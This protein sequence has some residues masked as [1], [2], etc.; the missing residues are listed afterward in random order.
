MFKVLSEPLPG[1]YILSNPCF[2]D[3]RGIF[4]KTFNYTL[5]KDLDIEFTPREQFSTISS[6]NVL[7]GMHFQVQESS[8]NKL[9]SCNSGSILDVIVDVRTSSPYY[10]MPFSIE[11]SGKSNQLV[12]IGKGYAHG[13]LSL[14]ED[15]L[16]SYT[17]DKEY[18]Q[19]LDSGVHWS[20][21]NY[22]WPVERPLV[23]TRDQMHPDIGEQKCEFF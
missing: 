6:K 8:H 16:V 11:L 10:N 1:V 9:V 15:T 13:F 21:I 17:T 22:H 3:E 4:F 12:F 14:E 23:S 18:N 20:S 2:T 7:R 5:F 19:S